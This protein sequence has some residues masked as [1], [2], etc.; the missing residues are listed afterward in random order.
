MGVLSEERALPSVSVAKL[1]EDLKAEVLCCPELTDKLVENIMI[2]AMSFGSG[3]DYFVRKDN[4]AVITRGEKHD[5]A[6][7]ALSTSTACLILSNGKQTSPQV[8]HWAEDKGVPVLSVE[9][10]V[11]SIVDEVE[12]TFIKAMSGEQEKSGESD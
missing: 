2:G 11:L 4:K 3:E 12:K 6:L 10:D 8:I 5:I 7:A 1:A 9:Q